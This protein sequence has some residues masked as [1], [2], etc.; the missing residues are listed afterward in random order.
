MAVDETPVLIV[1]GGPVGLGLAIDLGWRGIPC[2]L[3][4][5]SDGTINL[6]RANAIDLRTME[7]CRRWG[8]ADEIRKA[9]IPPDFPHSALYATALGGF[10]I[11][12]FER[13]GHG[14]TGGLDVSPERPQRCNQLFFDPILRAHTKALPSVDL[15]LSTRLTGFEQDD[16]GVTAQVTDLA[17]ERNYAI[18]ARYMVA[19]CGG[20]SPIRAIL[21]DPVPA[22]QG[23]IGHPVSVFFRAEALWEHHDKGKASL[24]FIVGEDGVWGTLIPLD[25]N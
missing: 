8:I 17:A 25:G 9:G 15:R 23:V 18:R 7:Y 24:N 13:R 4:E 3:L 21:C 5:Q 10:E 14:G 19:C 12:R 1:G 20:R 16:D 6:P 11:A 22:E 2:L